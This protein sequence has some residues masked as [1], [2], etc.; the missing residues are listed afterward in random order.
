MSESVIYVLAFLVLLIIA[1]FFFNKPTVN[2]KSAVIK[3]D[4]LI[5]KYENGMLEIIS[6]YQNDKKK[7]QM[8]KIEYLK[9]TSHQL[10]NN[11]FFEEHE[12]KKIIQR[13]ATL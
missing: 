1:F 12:A 3:R 6:T 13:L 4:E 9:K 8:K 7:L 10:H 5:K 2:K 11:I